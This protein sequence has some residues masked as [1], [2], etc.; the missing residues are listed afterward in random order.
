MI[1]S[2]KERLINITNINRH[3]N[4]PLENVPAYSYRKQDFI[5]ISAKDAYELYNLVDSLDLGVSYGTIPREYF[6]IKIGWRCY[7]SS[8]SGVVAEY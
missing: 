7:K 3:L 1:Q 2:K 5:T 6:K 4:F 8:Y